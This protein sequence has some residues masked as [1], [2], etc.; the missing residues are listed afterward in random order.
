M[1]PI[2]RLPMLLTIIAAVHARAQVPARHTDPKAAKIA[3]AMRAAGPTISRHATIADIDGTVLRPG[4]NGWTCKP[5]LSATDRSPICNDSVWVRFW[6]AYDVK[7]AF[8]TDRAGIGYMLAGDAGPGSNT[9]PF[10]EKQA[11]G[12]VWVREGPHVMV[13]LPDTSQLAG[14]STDP[15]NGGPYVMWAGTPYVHV[16]VPV[17]ARPKD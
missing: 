7:A 16:M 8:H 3:R 14:I 1:Q 4:S 11:P 17:G 12:D 15:N 5:G 13:I 10:A 6:I 9:D 2:T